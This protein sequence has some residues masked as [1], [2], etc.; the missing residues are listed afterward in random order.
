MSKNIIIIPSFDGIQG[1]PI[2]M[3][4][5]SGTILELNAQAGT[6]YQLVEA[7]SGVA[8][9][10]LKLQR[11]GNDLLIDIDEEGV[12]VILKNF[13][14]IAGSDLVG[15]AE[16]GQ[17]YTYMPASGNL[18]AYAANLVDGAGSV[19]V[20]VDWEGS[21]AVGVLLFNPALLGLAGLGAVGAGGGGATPA[22]EGVVDT[23]APLVPNV[24]DVSDKDADGKP[25]VSGKAEGNSKVT[26]TSPDGQTFTTMAD[27]AGNYSL[28]LSGVSSIEG[29]Y[30]VSA[31]DASNNV[32]AAATAS[33]DDFV[34]PPAPS[35][36]DVSDVNVDGN[37]EVSGTAEPDSTV[38][39]TAPDGKTFTTTADGTGDYS[40]ELSG[41]SPIAGT[42]TATSTDASNNVSAAATAS[43]DDFVAPLAP[44][45]TDVTDTDWDGKPEISGTA[46]PDSTVTITAPD[47]NTFTTTTDGTGGYSLELSGVSP[48]TGTYSVTATDA[49]NNVSPQVTRSEDDLTAPFVS[50]TLLSDEDHDDNPE[51]TGKAEVGSTVTITAPDGKTF[52][53]TADGS[54]DYSLELSGVSPIAGTYTVTAEDASHNVSA[55]V[56]ESGLVN[57]PPVN[58]AMVTGSSSENAGIQTLDL[59]SQTT[60]DNGDP[61]IVTLVTYSVDGSAASATA[62]G[63]SLSD[64]VLSID[65]NHWLFNRLAAGVDKVIAVNYVVDDGHGGTVNQSA[66]FTVTG[67]NDAPSVDIGVANGNAFGVFAAPIVIGVNVG[68]PAI[69]GAAVATNSLP[70]GWSSTDG[71][72]AVYVNDS[73]NT[74]FPTYSMSNLNGVSMDGGSFVQLVSGAAAEGMAF[75]SNQLTGLT[76]GVTYVYGVQWQ[77]VTLNDGTEDTYSGGELTIRIGDSDQRAYQSTPLDDGW[78]TALYQFTATAETARVDLGIN[79]TVGAFGT[80]GG[81]IV[82]DSL[83]TPQLEALNYRVG[84]GAKVSTIFGDVSDVS[85][86]DQG[87]DVSGWAITSGAASASSQ[88][89]YQVEGETEW[90]SLDGVSQQNAMFL[91]A[92]DLVRWTGL[93][94]TNT[95]LSARGVDDTSTDILHSKIDVSVNGGSTPYSANQGEIKATW[96]PLVLDLNHDGVHTLGTD[97][98]V[99]FDVSGHGPSV[100]GW[101][102]AQDGLL[103]LDLNQDGLINDGSELFGSST[104]LPDSTLAPDGF[105]ALRPYDF[106]MDEVIDAQDD[107][108]SQLQVW[109]DSNSDGQTDAGEL[110]SLADAGVAAIALG[111]QASSATQNGN[112]LA[113]VGSYLGTDGQFHEMID[114]IFAHLNVPVL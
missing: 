50:I 5:D 79:D 46:E 70:T 64:A 35:I 48:I 14:E 40:L 71:E 25:E 82:I 24:V 43:E 17:L 20:L 97:A 39:I 107:V 63:V 98:G 103:V 9:Q 32:S 27:D 56:T 96:T 109:V 66:R 78:L 23:T 4:A 102:S 112:Q 94:D 45:I 84:E 6:S 26:V 3:A 16:D 19:H 106:N 49:S 111:Y 52:T 87:S 61:L 8:P 76:P 65:T 74:A 58:T 60:D 36:T 15:T 104:R 34:A 29:T 10:T 1:Q 57:V 75:V 11:S 89:E 2:A 42:Y 55:P 108:F 110:L 93:R 62:A 38:T 85:D 41:V 68:G 83:S 101:V 73:G 30:S 7:D 95:M 31:T 47:G 90:R 53:T 81:S 114:V 33:E 86:V 54:G 22:G 88:W 59:L 51:V 113:L 69:D 67:I 18:D 12:D 28:E 21:A 72:N 105:A 91:A 13:Y 99:A 77:Q 80:V 92:D 100:T 37:P 44:T